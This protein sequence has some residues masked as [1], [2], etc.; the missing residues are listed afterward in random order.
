MGKI[1]ISSD[2]CRGGT[3]EWKTAAPHRFHNHDTG[4]KCHFQGCGTASQN[5]EEEGWH[6]SP[7]GD[8][9]QRGIPY[10]VQF[11]SAASNDSFILVPSHYNR[12]GI[13]AID[14]AYINYAK[15]EELT[16]V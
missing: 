3:K 11:T 2:S 15:F 8:T 1:A 7:H 13:T 4:L 5:G 9:R 10:N 14:R 16:M 6:Q 12:D